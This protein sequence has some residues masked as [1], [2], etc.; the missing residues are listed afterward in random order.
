MVDDAPV[1]LEPPQARAG[2][3]KRKFWSRALIRVT[4]D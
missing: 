1:F 4:E 2:A 3:A